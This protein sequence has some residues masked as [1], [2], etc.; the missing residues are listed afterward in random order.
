LD[1]ATAGSAGLASA[2][3]MQQ[4]IGERR[5][6]LIR[7]DTTDARKKWHQRSPEGTIRC[8]GRGER[9]SADTF[10]QSVRIVGG[11]VPTDIYWAMEIA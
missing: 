4:S 8:I 1:A 5:S 2:D 3:L 9:T 7:S 10:Q 6:R 11:N